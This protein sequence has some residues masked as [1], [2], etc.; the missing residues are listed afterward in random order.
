MQLASARRGA[1]DTEIIVL[2]Q[3]VEWSK[4]A[5]YRREDPHYKVTYVKGECSLYCCVSFDCPLPENEK[6]KCVPSYEKVLAA[7][8]AKLPGRRRTGV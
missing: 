7:V 2:D 5:I 4:R 1:T 3:S 6:L 8:R